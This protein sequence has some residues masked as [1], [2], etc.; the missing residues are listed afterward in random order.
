MPILTVGLA[1]GRA[2]EHRRRRAGDPRALRRRGAALR[3][4]ARGVSDAAAGVAR[5]PPRPHGGAPAPAAR[6][7]RTSA[8]SPRWAASR[9]RRSSRRTSRGVAYDD[10]ALPIGEDQT[11][12]QPF[13]VA[14]M[15]ELLALDGTERVLDVGTGSGYAAAVLDELAASVVSIERIPALAAR[16]RTGARRDGARTRRGA[17]RRREPRCARPRALRRD[18]RRGRDR[19][20]AAGAPRAARARAAG[21]CCPAAVERG[22]RLVRV[23]RT[24]TGRSRRPR[25]PAA[26]FPS[27]RAEPATASRVDRY[28]RPATM[29]EGTVT[30]PR[31]LPRGRV[32]AALRRRANWEQLVKFCVVGAIRLRRQPRRL[33]APA[34]GRRPPLR[35]RGD[36]LVPR[37][38]HEQLRLEPPVD[39]PGPARPRRLPGAP[40][41][42][43]LDD[44]ARREPRSCCTLLVQAGLGEV[45]AQALAIMLVTPVN[46]VGNKLW[47]FR[48]RR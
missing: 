11:I 31:E 4:A 43:R 30:T 7:H 8:C 27:S 42:R 48:H 32:D 38:R 13:I 37:R 24:A 1:C 6:D 18:R 45:V 12:S 25:S 20:R 2:R 19:P 34:R 46:F 22:Q 21:S 15:C 14:T 40:L 44:R 28:A 47:S 5:P 35:A 41:P 3:A 26:S 39:V 10:A 9:A 17:G 36:R 16:A 23:V 33:H 29:D